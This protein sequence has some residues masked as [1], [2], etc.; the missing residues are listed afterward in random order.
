[1]QLIDQNHPAG[2]GEPST[3]ETHDS[4]A[5]SGTA[6]TPLT[7]PN[8]VIYLDPNS[9]SAP[10]E[11]FRVD[12]PFAHDF[13][14]PLRQFSPPSSLH[15]Q[16]RR[17]SLLMTFADNY[18]QPNGYAPNDDDFC[19]LELW[20]DHT[21]HPSQPNVAYLDSSAKRR[22]I[23]IDPFLLI[24]DN[25]QSPQLLHTELSPHGSFAPPPPNNFSLF[26]NDHVCYPH[27]QAMSVADMSSLPQAAYPSFQGSN[28]FFSPENV[29]QSTQQIP[30]VQ[31]EGHC[32][33]PDFKFNE[34]IRKKI[35][36]DARTRLP[37]GE[38]V[39]A[40]FPTVDDLNYFFSGYMQCFHRHFPILHLWSLDVKE[41]P[42]PL[43]FAICSIGAQYRLSR[44]KAKNLFALAGTMSSYALRAGLPIVE[45]TPKPGPLWVM[46][47]RVLLSLCGMFSG[48]TNV[49]MRT[50]ENLGLFA[51]V[52]E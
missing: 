4:T 48:K 8:E 46:Q 52:R 17:A 1:L 49:V 12:Q 51:I 39:E 44:Q 18:S 23:E 21:P 13:Q 20:G 5:S 47:T 33:L 50:V 40:L 38:L 28:K 45:G 2:F 41:T 42:S 22:R 37:T 6:R 15:E 29:P 25:V 10:D 35:Y 32:E 3:Y 16:E 24:D 26:S 27:L 11:L 34:T 7:P 19:P 9:H 30:R 36:E 14:S 31:K 43:V